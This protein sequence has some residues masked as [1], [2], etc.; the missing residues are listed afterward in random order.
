M[1]AS[2][3]ASVVDP[4]DAAVTPKVLVVAATLAALVDVVAAVASDV[5]VSTVAMLP[6]QIW[7]PLSK[8]QPSAPARGEIAQQTRPRASSA[9]PDWAS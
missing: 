4:A 8:T 7:R 5:V 9:H 3:T 1:A 2:D 6:V